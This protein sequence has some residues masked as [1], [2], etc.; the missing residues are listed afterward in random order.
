MFSINNQHDSFSTTPRC[1]TRGRRNAMQCRLSRP[2]KTAVL[3]RTGLGGTS[4]FTLSFKKQ[5]SVEL[6]GGLVWNVHAA[7]SLLAVHLSQHFLTMG[8][9]MNE[10]V[11]EGLNYMV[12]KH[13]TQCNVYLC[14]ADMLLEE[15]RGRWHTHPAEFS[16][17]VVIC[18]LPSVAPGN[19]KHCCE[20]EAAKLRSI[21]SS[22]PPPRRSRYASCISLLN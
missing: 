15:V 18:P 4:G 10:W 16:F 5:S 20:P 3:T 11:G 13:T 12:F 2:V 21:C 14:Q 22:M 6:S 17:E 8:G 9:G 1:V 7:H 19:M